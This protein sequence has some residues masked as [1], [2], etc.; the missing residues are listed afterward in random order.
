VVCFLDC[1]L[2][3]RISFTL[4]QNQKGFAFTQKGYPVN[5]VHRV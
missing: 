3:I 1:G 2:I 4:C 5:P